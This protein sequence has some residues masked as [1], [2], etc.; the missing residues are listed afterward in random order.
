MSAR[1]IAAVLFGLGVHATAQAAC[2]DA[3]VTI[4]AT[5]AATVRAGP[6]RVHFVADADMA[7]GCLAQAAGC[8]RKAYVVPGNE[9]LVA[10]DAVF[11]HVCA[12]FSNQRGDVTSGWLP[13]AALAPI[14]VTPDDWTG[15]WHRTEAD[16]AIDPAKGGMLHV[17]GDATWGAFDPDR[18]K[19]GG[20]NIGEVEGTAAPR[21]GTLAFTVGTDRT[22]PY[23]EGDDTDCRIT[24]TRRGPYLVAKDN[25]NCGGHNVTFSGLYRRQG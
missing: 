15:K 4:A 8:G 16:L 5:R 19:R 9:V 1:I 3:N 6:P 7:T 13:E 2:M 22:L 18:V 24:L 14:A 10:G 11:G 21:G 20:V 23:G 17:Q 25:T 12:T